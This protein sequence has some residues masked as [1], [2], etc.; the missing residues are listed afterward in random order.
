MRRRIMLGRGQRKHKNG[1]NGRQA[2][3]EVGQEEE[4][5]EDGL[6]MLEGLPCLGRL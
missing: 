1:E 5:M 3:D 2:G 6:T 4:A